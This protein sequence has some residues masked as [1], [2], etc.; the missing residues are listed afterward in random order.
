MCLQGGYKKKGGCDVWDVCD[1]CSD[2]LKKS[3]SAQ[4]F[5][6]KGVVD[7]CDVCDICSII[8]L[9]ECLIVTNQADQG[10]LAATSHSAGIVGLSH[11]DGRWGLAL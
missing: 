2:S 9:N 5:K 6:K 10:S 7:V 11:L 1:V 4:A 8:S 3:V